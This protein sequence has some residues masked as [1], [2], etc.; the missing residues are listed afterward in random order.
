[1]SSTTGASLP[2]GIAIA[3]GLVPNSGS[4]PPH[5]AMWFDARHRGVDAD[6]AVRERHR[7]V[8]RPAPAWLE[9]RAPTQPTPDARASS[10]ARLAAVGHHQMADAVVAIDQRGRGRTL[11][12]LDVGLRIDPPRLS[13]AHIAGSRNTPW[14]SKPVR[15]ASIIAA[16]TD[17]RVGRGQAAGAQG[18]GEKS[19]QG[20]GGHAPAY[21]GSWSARRHSHGCCR[22]SDGVGLAFSA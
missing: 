16:A 11:D 12:H 1:M 8:D 6:H 21:L 10:M 3:I 4:A 15:S 2:A 22:C 19:P 13:V 5:G 7:R 14:A 20:G 9:R 18:V 17:R